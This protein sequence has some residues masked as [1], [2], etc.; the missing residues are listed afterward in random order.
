[1]GAEHSQ[2]EEEGAG[3]NSAGLLWVAPSC[4][5]AAP[6]SRGP[7]ARGSLLQGLL[8]VPLNRLN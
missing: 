6:A 1:M 5:V 2:V 7:Q 3:Y 8:G 4:P